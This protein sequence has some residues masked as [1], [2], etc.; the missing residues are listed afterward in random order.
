[1]TFGHRPLPLFNRPTDRLFEFDICGPGR[2]ASWRTVMKSGGICYLPRS[3]PLL[4]HRP[5]LQKMDDAWN[6]CVLMV[7]RE[8]EFSS[9]W[10]D[11]LQPF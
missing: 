2:R 8:K 10:S 1:M 9:F 7:F 11:T 3:L 4:A 5:R 6:G